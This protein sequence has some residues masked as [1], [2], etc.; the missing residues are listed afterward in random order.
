MS[1]DQLGLALKERDAPPHPEELRD[2]ITQEHPADLANFALAWPPRDAW[3]LLDLLPL[4]RQAEVFG[5]LPPDFQVGMADAV[6]RDRLARL[7]TEM[8]A[9]ERADLYNELSEE[10]RTAL[11]PALS[12]AER[13]DI[14]SW[15]AIRARPPAES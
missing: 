13:E 10:Q 12:Q 3:R 6:A 15:R 8:N 5:Y 7:V 2:F 9:D 1:Y 14:R 4:P 11:L